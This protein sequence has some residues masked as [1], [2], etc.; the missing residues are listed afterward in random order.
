ML[1]TITLLALVANAQGG[2][3]DT[4]FGVVKTVVNNN[5]MIQVGDIVKNIA[6][7]NMV[8]L[9]NIPGVDVGGL[10]NGVGGLVGMK[11]FGGSTPT[12]PTNMNPA[13]GDQSGGDQSGGDQSGGDQSGGW[14]SN[15]FKPNSG[16]NTNS[17]PSNSW[18]GNIFGGGGGMAS[19]GPDPAD[20]N[21]P[22]SGMNDPSS[23]G[24]DPNAGGQTSNKVG[25]GSP[26][27]GV[28]GTCLDSS[29][30]SC[31]P[32]FL[33]GKCPG[34]SEV[35]CCP[36]GGVAGT[37]SGGNQDPDQPV[38]SGS[39]S[40]ASYGGL[41]FPLA[42]G[43]L[44]QISSNWG[45]SRQGGAR[46]HAGLDILTTGAR[47]IVAMSDGEVV[48]IMTDWYKCRGNS[49]DAIFVYH[50]TGALAGKTINYG[51]VDPG[52][53]SVRA[54]DQVRRGQSLGT[55]RGCGMLHFE[56]YE[57]RRSVNM[58]WKPASGRVGPGCATNSMHTKP[59]AMLDPRPV[60][61][62]TLP[63]NARFKNGAGLLNS[64]DLS[65]LNDELDE[66]ADFAEFD[67]GAIV[68]IVIG[69]LVLVALVVGVVVFV[70]MRRAR[71]A[72]EQEG[73][74]SI[75]NAAYATAAPADLGHFKCEQ[76]GK[77]YNYENDLQIHMST[78]HTAA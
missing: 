17:D 47:Q 54:G 22:N 31:M 10:L 42:T 23:G 72:A 34:P 73:T 16:T 20:M 7:T 25:V 65:V 33:I 21:D 58:Y 44:N 57:G 4:L 32:K 55:G 77:E 60:I 38:S 56:L 52:S 36:S 5:G 45:G 49:I 18:L 53:Y 50:T 76:C 74:V 62:C 37:V 78:R 3:F 9:P 41:V 71:R 26:C 35:R 43:S 64:G 68:G 67:A 27:R 13:G 69:V 11:I 14:L 59:A 19:N 75:P 8:N 15:L 66:T 30:S 48:N 51:E 24:A 70:R 6:M 1:T 2:I 12:T 46:C 61:R 28:A 40:C 39:G 63:A 29:V